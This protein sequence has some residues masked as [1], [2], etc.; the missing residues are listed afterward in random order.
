MKHNNNPPPQSPKE[1]ICIS[2]I[3]LIYQVLHTFA[4]LQD[5]EKVRTACISEAIP[6]KIKYF[7]SI[8]QNRALTYLF[9]K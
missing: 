9:S 7:Q 2:T 8:G 1:A 4:L 6:R 5:C 3:L